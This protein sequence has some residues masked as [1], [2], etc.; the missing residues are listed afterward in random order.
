VPVGIQGVVA[1]ALLK[2][3]PGCDQ[4]KVSMRSRES[5]DVCAVARLFG[6]G[7]HMHAAGFEVADSLE[8]ARQ[9]V[10]EQLQ[11]QLGPRSP[12]AETR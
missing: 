1:S 12:S 6:G 7:G 5:V 9:S 3:L 11:A 4:I 10:A 8:N 2:E